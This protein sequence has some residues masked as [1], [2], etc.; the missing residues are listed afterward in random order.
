MA[1]GG[2]VA[3]WLAGGGGDEA[4]TLAGGTPQGCPASPLIWV[5]VTDYALSVLRAKGNDD[6]GVDRS[7]EVGGEVLA[8][9]LCVGPPSLS[10]TI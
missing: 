2:W 5:V 10:Q 8:C 1:V 7:I 4:V 9:W 3:G 6:D